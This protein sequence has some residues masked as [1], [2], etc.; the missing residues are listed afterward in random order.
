MKLF[1]LLF[2][3]GLSLAACHEP[4]AIS[5]F[6]KSVYR[7][8]GDSQGNITSTVAKYQPEFDAMNHDGQLGDTLASL[9]EIRL[10]ELKTS[11]Q[12]AKRMSKVIQEL[13][14]HAP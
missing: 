5:R 13:N 12:H 7:E 2:L 3:A 11:I 4:S 8:L 9:F 1:S 6:T 14:H 10:M